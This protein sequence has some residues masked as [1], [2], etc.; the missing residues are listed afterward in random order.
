MIEQRQCNAASRCPSLVAKTVNFL[1]FKK[2]YSV[3]PYVKYNSNKRQQSL[4]AQ[5]CSGTLPLV[6]TISGG[7]RY[8]VTPEE[9]SVYCVSQVKLKMV[10]VLYCTAYNYRRAVLLV[11]MLIV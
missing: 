8:N 10:S 1:S 2:R 4:C 9:D 3:E 6:I 7:C 11:F 5:L